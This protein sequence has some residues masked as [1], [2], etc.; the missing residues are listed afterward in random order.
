MGR[1]S[2]NGVKGTPNYLGWSLAWHREI[3]NHYT[4][5]HASFTLKK[6]VKTHAPP[7]YTSGDGASPVPIAGK[8][9]KLLEITY[10]AGYCR[11]P[12]HFRI[13]CRI[14]PLDAG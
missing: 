3:E 6:S 10:S 4:S 13:A 9:Q 7:W 14:L 8:Y 1:T 12:L 2:E 5:G 11:L